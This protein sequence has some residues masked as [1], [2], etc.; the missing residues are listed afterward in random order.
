MIDHLL[1]LPQIEQIARLARKAHG[2]LPLGESAVLGAL[3]A[4]KPSLDY[5]HLQM[6]AGQILLWQIGT[7]RDQALFQVRIGNGL[8]Q[9]VK[10]RHAQALI[11]VGLEQA[12]ALALGQGIGAFE[13]DGL[14]REATGIGRFCRRDWLC[15]FAWQVLE[16]FEAP[17]LLFEQAI[18]AFADKVSVA[19]GWRGI[20]RESGERQ[21][22]ARHNLAHRAGKDMFDP[23]SKKR[24]PK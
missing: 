20:N 6:P 12:L 9:L 17:T 18:L 4:L 10:L 7:A 15:F 3:Q 23:S 2:Q 16:F 24:H 5:Q 1:D 22:K 8:E 19:R 14:D 11:D 13:L 21:S